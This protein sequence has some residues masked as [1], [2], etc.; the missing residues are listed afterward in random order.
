MTKFRYAMSVGIATAALLAV[1]GVAGAQTTKPAGEIVAPQGLDTRERADLPPCTV[2]V[3]KKSDC[4][5]HDSGTHIQ[6]TSAQ[7]D[8]SRPHAA[9]EF[10]L[11]MKAQHGR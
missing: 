8:A 11:F 1:G 9:K 3:I 7:P 10:D 2:E 4:H 5:I 6:M